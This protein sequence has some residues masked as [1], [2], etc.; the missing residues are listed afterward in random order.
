M[1]RRKSGR[2]KAAIGRSEQ[3]YGER[4]KPP[5]PRWQL[6]LNRVGEAEFRE[7]LENDH[8]S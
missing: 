5:D 6:L 1:Q 2:T 7:V 8:F 4:D 3:S